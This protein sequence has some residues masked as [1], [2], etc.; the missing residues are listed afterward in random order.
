ML[1]K[2]LAFM[3]VA[4]VFIGLGVSGTLNAA[5]AGYHSV[6]SNPIAQKLQSKATNAIISAATQIHNIEST[7]AHVISS[8]I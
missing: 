4:L 6:I 8:K 5:L 2:L 3:F 1:L 7:A